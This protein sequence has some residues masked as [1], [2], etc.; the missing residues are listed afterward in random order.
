[1]ILRGM[2]IM[3]KLLVK[4]L[5]AENFKLYGT[6][7]NMINPKR[8]KLG[9]EPVEF[10]R[11]MEQLCLGQ[12][13]MASF[14]VTRV[15]KRPLIIE[16]LEFHSYTG[17][18]IL[19]LDGDVLIHLGIATKSG[20]VPVDKIEVFRVPQGTLV[21]IRPGVWHHAPFAINNDYVNVVVVLPERTYMND[22]V[23]YI[24]PDNEKLEIQI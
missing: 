6:F 17:E 12:T 1:M 8:P 7:A 24:I 23:V 15:S 20:V 2:F 22:C 21:T 9:P 14:S 5:T 3:E 16:K 10:Y 13:G 11:D 18:A 4:E 19:P